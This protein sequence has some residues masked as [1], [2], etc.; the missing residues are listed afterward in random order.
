[1]AASKTGKKKSL[2]KPQTIH[3][4]FALRSKNEIYY[5]MASVF[6][7]VTKDKDELTQEMLGT[8]MSIKNP[9]FFVENKL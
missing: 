4:Y 9:N 8:L 1:M 2:R 3:T 6:K 7:A 5:Q